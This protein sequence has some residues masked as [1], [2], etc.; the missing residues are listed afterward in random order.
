MFNRQPQAYADAAT[1]VRLWLTVKRYTVQT[2]AKQ[3]ELPGEC[4]QNAGSPEG[5]R[6]FRYFTR[7]SLNG[8]MFN[9]QPKAYADAATNVRLRLTVKQKTSP[10]GPIKVETIVNS[11]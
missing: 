11:R 4:L 5:L 1:N 6:R 2:V 8:V 9:R 7:R 10:S 3:R